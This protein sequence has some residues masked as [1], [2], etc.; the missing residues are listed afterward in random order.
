ML[1]RMGLRGAEVAG[2]GDPAN[3]EHSRSPVGV[4]ER[5]SPAVATSAESCKRD[6]GVGPSNS[7]LMR[8]R[9]CS[10][11]SSATRQR[12]TGVE[13]NEERTGEG[14]RTEPDRGRQGR[15]VR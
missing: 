4:L 14:S 15:T 12:E 1:A 6:Q 13:L 8:L 5:V 11:I 2:E 10:S 9:T 3:H 7:F